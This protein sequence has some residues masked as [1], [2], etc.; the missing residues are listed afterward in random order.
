LD[1]PVRLHGKI[2][3]VV[4]HEHLGPMRNWTTEEQNFAASIADFV[5]LSIETAE[6]KTTEISLKDSEKKYRGLVH[7][8]NTGIYRTTPQG[9]IIEANPMFAHISGYNS[10]QSLLKLPIIKLYQNPNDRKLFLQKMIRDGQVK[11][12]EIIQRK[13]DGSLINVSIT[14]RAHHNDKGQ[15]DWYDGV[16]EDITERKKVQDALKESEER[17]RTVFETANDG[18]LV[19]SPSG[20]VLSANQ[21]AFKI[22]GLSEKAIGLN[23]AKSGVLPPHSLEIIQKNMKARLSGKDITPYE[24]EIYPK[25]KN[26]KII[27]EISASLLRDTSGKVIADLAIIRDVTE[28]KQYEIELKKA[29]EA[30]EAANKAKTA[31]LHNMSHEL[32]TPL[33]SI[34]GF[35]DVLMDNET[36]LDNKEM[37]SIVKNSGNHL[38]K[39]I[40]NLLDLSKIEAGR[41]KVENS[42]C[43][44]KDLVKEL[45]QRYKLIAYEKGIKYRVIIKKNLPKFLITDCTKINQIVSNLLDNAFKFTEQGT[46]D[47]CLGLNKPIRNKKSILE[48]QV[49]DTGIGIP[50]DRIEHIFDKFEQGEYYISK[51]YGGAGLGLP[52][53]KQLTELM[54]GTISVKSK[55][56]QG[57][58]F[59]VLLPIEIPDK[60]Q[61]VNN[62]I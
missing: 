8:V 13:K 7:N 56:A 28:R 9:K 15:I 31:F 24:I 60:K 12:Y 14:A 44:S 47:L 5:S 19:I 38:L 59:T 48:I 36:D 25:N 18:I 11:N 61:E 26:S 10:T 53:I 42:L 32:R 54:Q 43:D 16:V 29:K 33:T 17:Y 34:I 2:I 30:A 3:G 39:I 45:Q 4:C 1:V 58:K 49:K 62:V 20:V 35:T 46:V 57:T 52:I 21:Q 37:L 40:N 27:V 51:K 23:I 22:S 6:H 50:K 55:L 41:I